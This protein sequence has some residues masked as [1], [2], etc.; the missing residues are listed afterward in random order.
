MLR[1]G[2][3]VITAKTS[4]MSREKL[5][6]YMVGREIAQTYY[7]RVRDR[8]E[9]HRRAD[10]VLVVENV[11]MGAAVK[12]M[13]F[14]IYAGEVVGIAGLIGSGAHGDSPRSFSAR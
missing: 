14:S 12:N 5:V 9:R 1:D 4:E 8:S 2:K 11:T 6:R 3:V 10:K 7:A 13:S